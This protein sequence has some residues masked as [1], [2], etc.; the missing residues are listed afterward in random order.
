RICEQLVTPAVLHQLRSAGPLSSRL[1]RVVPPQR[2]ALLVS[3]RRGRSPYDP[4]T[5]LP[6]AK[7][8]IH[9][10]VR[11]RQL[12]VEA[13]EGQEL[14]ALHEHARRSDGRDVLSNE[15]PAVVAG[16]AARP[17]VVGVSGDA[18]GS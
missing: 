8:E 15:S 10:V 16:R 5:C 1:A 12:L 13:A 18:P 7:A 2:G 11:N 6:Q 9:V 17:T 4:L 14:R 3:K